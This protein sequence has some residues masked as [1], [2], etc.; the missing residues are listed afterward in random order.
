MFKF[1]GPQYY[2]ALTVGKNVWVVYSITKEKVGV[3]KTTRG[4]AEECVRR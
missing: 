4:G 3:T 1:G 2:K